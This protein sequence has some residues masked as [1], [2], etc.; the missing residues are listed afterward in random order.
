MM[1]ARVLILQRTNTLLHSKLRS[2]ER[3]ISLQPIKNTEN[4]RNIDSKSQSV[5]G[6]ETADMALENENLRNKL[7]EA[8]SEIQRLNNERKSLLD[9]TLTLQGKI[10][11][12]CRLR[13]SES[14]TIT[15]NIIGNEE[16][17]ISETFFFHCILLL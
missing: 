11:V 7:N 16:L 3:R 17:K 14:E 1:N 10:R 5:S 8:A 9:M 2:A 4:A 6:K 12:F 15:Y 13:P